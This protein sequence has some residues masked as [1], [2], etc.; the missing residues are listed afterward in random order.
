M[1]R[2]S[3]RS[4]RRVVAGVSALPS[5]KKGVGTVGE[6]RLAHDQT[7]I[8]VD[9]ADDNALTL[10]D[11]G[12]YRGTRPWR[13]ADSGRYTGQGMLTP[14]AMVLLVA[15]SLAAGQ[16]M[17]SHG[18]KP[19]TRPAPSGRPWN[20]TLTNIAK[21]AGLTAPIIY[22]TDS[23]A[24]YITETT[25][26]GI[27][28]LD[29]DGDGW[30]DIFIVGGT[31][32]DGNPPEATNRLYRNKHDGTFED[33]TDRA[34]L[35]RTGWGNGVTVARHRQR[36]T[37]RPVRDLLGRER[38]VS[39]Q[40]RRHVHRYHRQDGAGAQTEASVSLLV[41]G[42]DVPGLRPRRATWTCSS[43]PTSI[44][45]WPAYPS[46]ERTPILQLEG[47]ADRLRAARPAA[48]TAFPVPQS[49]RRHLR[50]RLAEERESLKSGNCFGLTAVSADFDGDGWP[51]VYA[52]LR[53]DASQLLPQQSR[54]Y[55]HRRGHRAR[56]S[57]EPGRHGAGGYGHRDRR[58][59]RR[60]ASSTS[61]RR[62]LPTTPRG[63]TRD[64]RAGSTATSLSGPGSQ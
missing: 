58:L 5:L 55:L 35:R 28:F 34:G 40:R 53:L 57:A 50:G 13:L 60:R 36:R 52:G 49:R 15:A 16:G 12:G 4:A 43:I 9:V 39:Q 23:R 14:R 17:I 25:A 47:R 22:G 51:D 2:A 48:R 3:V 8:A 21:E 31:R 6:I 11:V 32:L 19:A 24:E 20:S 27:A 61:S 59:R 30:L 33:V 29:Y 42:R 56:R 26:G 46:A 41:F 7:P 45:T 54:R 44:S 63:S 18:V 62:I 37:P 64:G 38:A 10:F 1:K